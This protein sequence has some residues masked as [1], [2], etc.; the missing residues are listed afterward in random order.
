MLGGA[1]NLQT[2]WT[3]LSHPLFADPLSHHRPRNPSLPRLAACFGGVLGNRCATL[4]R[5]DG[6]FG[7]AWA[8]REGDVE[9]IWYYTVVLIPRLLSRHVWPPQPFI[10]VF[11]VLEK[12]FD[13]SLG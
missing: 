6:G 10:P 2:I 5:R 8:S 4:C 12:D 1:C 13:L 3:V 11:S 9:T 7:A